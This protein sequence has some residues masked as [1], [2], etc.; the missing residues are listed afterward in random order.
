[1]DYVCGMGFVRMQSIFYH[2]KPASPLECDSADKYVVIGDE[3]GTIQFA[4]MGSLL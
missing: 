2:K 3:F 1:M 4:F